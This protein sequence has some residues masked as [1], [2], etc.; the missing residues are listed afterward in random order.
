MKQMVRVDPAGV[1][2]AVPAGRSLMAAAQDAGI[3]WPNVCGGQA[4]CGVCAVEVMAGDLA[5]APPSLREAQMLA[6]LAI[7]PLHGGILRLACQIAP[8]APLTVV[9]LGVRKPG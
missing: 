7:R 9:K 1:E 6:R 3:R 5:G 4:Q 2:V 8:A